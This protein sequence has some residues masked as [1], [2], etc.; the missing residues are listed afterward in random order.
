MKVE[1]DIIEPPFYLGG[2][3]NYFSFSPLLWEDFQFDYL[4]FS[5]GLKPPTSYLLNIRWNVPIQWRCSTGNGQAERVFCERTV[6]FI[7]NSTEFAS[8]LRISIIAMKPFH[9]MKMPKNLLGNKLVQSGSLF[10]PGYK[11]SIHRPLVPR[12]G[13]RTCQQQLHGLDVFASRDLAATLAFGQHGRS[14]GQGLWGGVMAV[15][16]L[17]L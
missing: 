6:R 17:R 11:T 14:E 7:L 12:W 10:H 1:L 3:L 2:G 9:Y 15:V 16:K 13:L 8:E 4:M 5:D